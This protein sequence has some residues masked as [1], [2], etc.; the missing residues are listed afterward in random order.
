MSRH[1]LLQMITLQVSLMLCTELNTSD[2]QSLQSIA[3]LRHFQELL[4]GGIIVVRLIKVYEV[5]LFEL[6][7]ISHVST[8][9]HLETL[10]C[11]AGQFTFKLCLL[12]DFASISNVALVNFK[13]PKNLTEVDKIQH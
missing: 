4:K 3:I 11:E 9:P 10:K 5:L 7:F 12:A 1:F 8:H 13:A 6:N 2:C